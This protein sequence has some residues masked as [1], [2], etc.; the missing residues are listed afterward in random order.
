MSTVSKRGKCFLVFA[1]ATQI[2]MTQIPCVVTLIHD[3]HSRETKVCSRAL[4]LNE[5]C[6]D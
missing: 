6:K 2:M 3:N 5:Y 4:I 1:R